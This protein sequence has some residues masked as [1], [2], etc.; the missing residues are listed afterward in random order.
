MGV[1]RYYCLEWVDKY[2]INQLGNE[3]AIGKIGIIVS[4]HKKIPRQREQTVSAKLCTEKVAKLEAHGLIKPITL[5]CT[6]H[7][8]GEERWIKYREPVFSLP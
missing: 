6:R 4:M 8:W 1:N 2:V 5:R 7:F 3:D